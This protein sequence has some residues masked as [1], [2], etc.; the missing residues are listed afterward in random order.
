PVVI[1]C[2]LRNPT[3]FRAGVEEIVACG[4]DCDTTGAILGGILGARLGVGAIPKD[5]SESIWEWP[6]SPRS[7]ETL[8][9]NLAN[10]L[11]GKPI[12][13]VPRLILPFQLLRNIFFFGIVLGHVVRRLLPP[14]R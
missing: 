8:A 6:N 5:W 3:N 11:E 9:Q 4:G 14:Y 7:I 2:L 1:Q 10:G 12:E 13:V